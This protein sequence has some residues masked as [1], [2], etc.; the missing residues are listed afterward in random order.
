VGENPGKN[1]IDMENIIRTGLDPQLYGVSIRPVLLPSHEGRTAIILHIPQSY[2]LPHMVKTSGR[3]YARNS[4]GKFPLDVAQLRNAF[5]LAG[6]AAERI[7]LFRIERLSKIGAGVETPVLLDEQTAKI[8]LHMIPLSAFSTTISV[9]IG[10]L[11]DGIK[12][13][14]FNPLTAWD[15]PSTVDMR[16]NVDGIMRSVSWGNPPSIA[17]YTQVFRNGIIE[18]VDMSILGI[19]AWNAD[20]FGSKVEKKS[21]GGVLYEKMLLGET[22][23]FVPVLSAILAR[24]D[25]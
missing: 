3:F 4:V 13:E 15:I 21:F 7:R 6:T 17:A 5:G 10:P 25:E 19:N 22:L 23:C 11:Y 16:F 12:G 9:N 1:I 18:T 14:L 24:D 20:T 2:A 8:V